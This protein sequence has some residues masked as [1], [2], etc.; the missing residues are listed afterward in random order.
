MKL[1]AKDLENMPIEQ[2]RTL[3]NSMRLPTAEEKEIAWECMDTGI[4]DDKGNL[5]GDKCEEEDRY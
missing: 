3:Y 4:Y 2:L 5:I 1:T